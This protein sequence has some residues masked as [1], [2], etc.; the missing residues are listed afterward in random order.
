VDALRADDLVQA[1]STPPAEKLRQALEMMG[2][3]FELR[4]AALRLRFP[5]ASEVEIQAMF[6]RWLAGD[7]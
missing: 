6:T 1:R 2:V 4:L 5:E 3:G 7:E